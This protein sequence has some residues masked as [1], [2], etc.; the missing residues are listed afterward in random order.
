M[1]FAV[2]SSHGP[3]IMMLEYTYKANPTL[4]YVTDLPSMVLM[5]SATCVMYGNVF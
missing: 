2:T 4:S 3:S 5:L 1:Y